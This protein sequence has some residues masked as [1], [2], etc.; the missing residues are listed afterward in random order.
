MGK[1]ERHITAIT[2][3]LDVL[4]SRQ[5][6]FCFLASTEQLNMPINKKN[7]TQEALKHSPTFIFLFNKTHQSSF[8]T[9][10]TPLFS[11]P[12]PDSPKLY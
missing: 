4:R 10:Y 3:N 9:Q 1:Y 12:N 11:S 5:V 8:N 2:H 6:I 7:S